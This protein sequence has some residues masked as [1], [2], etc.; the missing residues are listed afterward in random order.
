M[1]TTRTA[2]AVRRATVAA[3]LEARVDQVFVF[4]FCFVVEKHVADLT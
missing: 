1:A 3:A 2:V 4:I